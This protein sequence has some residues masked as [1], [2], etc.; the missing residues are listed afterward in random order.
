MRGSN[1]A[2]VQR[3]QGLLEVRALTEKK[4]RRTTQN[5][6]AAQKQ[7]YG[8]SFKY[9]EFYVTSSIWQALLLSFSFALAVALMFVPPVSQLLDP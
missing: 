3:T 7:R 5:Y 9:D 4:M 6:A 2:I 8:P 1:T